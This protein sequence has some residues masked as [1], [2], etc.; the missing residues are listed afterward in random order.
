MDL[1]SYLDDWLALRGS[2]IKPRTRDQYADLIGRFIAPAIGAVELDQLT[3]DDVRHVLASIAATGHTRTAELVYVLLRCALSDRLPLLMLGVKRPKHR[4][5]HPQP[6]LD[7]QI[8]AYVAALADHPHG[9]AL[10]LAILMGLRRGEICGLRWR[11]VDFDAEEI[12]VVNQRVRLMDGSLVDCPPKSECSVRDVPIP[13]PLLTALRG[14]RGL[15][16]AYVCRLTPSGLSHAH[17][18]LV[19]ALALP[20]LGLHGLRHSFATA[21]MKHNG[22]ARS[23]QSVL[24]HSSYAVTMNIYTHPDHDMKSRAV[25]SAVTCWYNVLHR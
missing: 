12:H 20:P 13:R 1:K 11:D 19:E 24:G 25:D 15:P 16:D 17:K 4:Q 8:A 21:S 14:A 10:S 7:G 3:A 5:K 6:W 9:V 18:R 2:D 22:D 23:L